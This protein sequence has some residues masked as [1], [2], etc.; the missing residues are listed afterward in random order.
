MH[1]LAVE[2]IYYTSV[3]TSIPTDGIIFCITNVLISNR[4]DGTLVIAGAR[5]T[6]FVRV[7]LSNEPWNHCRLVKACARETHRVSF[8][9]VGL[10][11][12]PWNYL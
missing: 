3:Q 6:I 11:H 5:E 4:G 8:A 7:S 2:W 1:A 10:V 12:E 9:R